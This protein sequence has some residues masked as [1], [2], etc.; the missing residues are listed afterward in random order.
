MNLITFEMP[1][2][3]QTAILHTFII[4]AARSVRQDRHSGA[5]KMF[6]SA[7]I[8]QSYSKAYFAYKLARPRRDR[9]V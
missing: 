8:G 2:I 7:R 4:N 3:S 1:H 5:R 6:V 9:D